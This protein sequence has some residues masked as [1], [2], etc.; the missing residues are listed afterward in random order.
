[1]PV[2]GGQRIRPGYRG[3]RCMLGM[4]D[5]M[6]VC[7]YTW[8][9]LLKV[10]DWTCEEINRKI[11]FINVFFFLKIAEVYYREKKNGIDRDIN[12]RMIWQKWAMDQWRE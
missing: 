2:A 8:K 1:M 3:D 4:D 12:Y 9:W 11:L 6:D 10:V 5:A 7:W